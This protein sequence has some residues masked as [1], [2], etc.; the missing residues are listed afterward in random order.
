MM[1]WCGEARY[2]IEGVYV[3]IPAALAVM[4]NSHEYAGWFR[5]AVAVT[6][7]C[8]IAGFLAI[9][10]GYAVIQGAG[11]LFVL[12]T[13]S[14]GH[15]AVWLSTALDIVRVV[16]FIAAGLANVLLF[17]LWRRRRAPRSSPLPA[18]VRPPA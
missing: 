1:S 5:A 11:G 4:G 9:Y 8:G 6:L 15:D 17:E 3:A 16:A 7:P 10:G 14:T 13:T 18:N 12:T 2:A